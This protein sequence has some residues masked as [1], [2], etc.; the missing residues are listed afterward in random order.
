MSTDNRAKYPTVWH[1]G[2]EDVRMRIPILRKLKGMGFRVG[3]VGSESEAPF[4]EAGIP[5]WKY[6]LERWVNPFADRKSV[7]QLTALFSKHRPDVVH[8]FDTKPAMLAMHA[9]VAASIPGRV[10][11]INGM[12]YVFSSRSPVALSLRPIYR[13]LQRKASRVSSNTAFQNS[14]D[15]DYFLKNKMVTEDKAE[16]ILSSGIDGDVVR[17]QVHDKEGLRML[18]HELGIDGGVV[19]VMIARM[20]R[21]KGV[22]EFLEAAKRIKSLYSNYTFLLV[23]PTGT[24]GRQAVS[25]SEIQKYSQYVQYLGR[26]SDVPSLLALS[27]IVVLP[28]YYREGVPRILLEAGVLG[29]PM[30]TTDMPGCRDVVHDGKNGFLVQPRS[31][32]SVA[33]SIV[34]LGESEEMRLEFGKYAM[35]H[36]ES[37]FSLDKVAAAYADIYLR[38]SSW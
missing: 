38:Y 9:A 19:V 5:Y 8:G 17:G 7:A 14:D 12:G 1:V 10:R 27:D 4:R 29:K 22:R 28:S 15:L 18:R 33:D 37:V 31:S 2:G 36:T 26:R 25:E 16:L 32:K 30:I 23:G 3:A 21:N 6:D 11:T 35:L 20:V 13:H 34:K 24:E